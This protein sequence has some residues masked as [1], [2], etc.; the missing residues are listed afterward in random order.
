MSDIYSSIYSSLEEGVPGV[1]ITSMSQKNQKDNIKIFIDKN[2]KTVGDSIDD[3]KI[4]V[5][6]K[7]YVL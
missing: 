3:K 4:M 7:K 5:A 6:L 1:L 2:E